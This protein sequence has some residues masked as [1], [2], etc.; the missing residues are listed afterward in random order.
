MGP[1]ALKKTKELFEKESWVV[2]IDY[3]TLETAIVEGF[4]NQT[5]RSVH[6]QFAQHLQALFGEGASEFSPELLSSL[7]K[8]YIAGRHD[9]EVQTREPTVNERDHTMEV[10]VKALRKSGMGLR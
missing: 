3:A 7:K 2:G 5:E 6:A 4:H 9:V 1:D 8:L 10:L